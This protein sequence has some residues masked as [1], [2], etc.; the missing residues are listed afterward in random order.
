MQGLCYGSAST[1]S[2]VQFSRA[3]RYK[4][5]RQ[6]TTSHDFLQCALYM[7]YIQKTILSSQQEKCAPPRRTSNISNVWSLRTS[8]THH[9]KCRHE[10]RRSPEDTLVN[11]VNERHLGVLCC[12]SNTITERPNPSLHKTL[13]VCVCV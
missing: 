8:D 3:T 9:N 6:R 12:V 4:W 2:Q 13:C 7:R 1:A 11:G 10:G 5:M